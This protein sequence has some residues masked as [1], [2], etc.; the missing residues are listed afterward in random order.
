MYSM[1]FYFSNVLFM[2]FFSFLNFCLILVPCQ[3]KM[4]TYILFDFILFYFL[5]RGMVNNCFNIT[6]NIIIYFLKLEQNI[7]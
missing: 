1:I 7:F 6:R 5:F 3:K 4:I 2:Y